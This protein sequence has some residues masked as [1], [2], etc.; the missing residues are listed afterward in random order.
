MDSYSVF[1]L[2]RYLTQGLAALINDF[3]CALFIPVD[4]RLCCCWRKA[5]FPLQVSWKNP[6]HSFTTLCCFLFLADLQGVS[7]EELPAQ[8]SQETEARLYQPTWWCE[9]YELTSIQDPI[10]GRTPFKLQGHPKEATNSRVFYHGDFV[11]NQK[12]EIL[13]LS[14]VQTRVKDHRS[15]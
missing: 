12:Q 6:T 13:V 2:A 3:R 5:L 10:W 1:Y 11:W 14:V 4:C 9:V 7:G 8:S 15:N